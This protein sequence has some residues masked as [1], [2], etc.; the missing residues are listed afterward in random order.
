VIVG[1][2]AVAQRIGELAQEAG[3]AAG[4]AAGVAAG[5]AGAG[6]LQRVEQFPECG[7]QR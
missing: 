1:A 6:R 7:L 4:A 3:Q 5:L 2:A